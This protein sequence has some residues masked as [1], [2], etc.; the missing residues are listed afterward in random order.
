MG[1]ILAKDQTASMQMIK[2]CLTLTYCAANK[3]N[4][5][6]PAI[7]LGPCLKNM[8]SWPIYSREYQTDQDLRVDGNIKIVDGG[9][10]TIYSN[11]SSPEDMME[12]EQARKP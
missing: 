9:Q 10:I 2:H 3:I 1:Y 12:E 6:W 11:D 4:L 7:G 8:L 5:K